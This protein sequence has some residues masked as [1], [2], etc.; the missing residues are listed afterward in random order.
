MLF[1]LN[2]GPLLKQQQMWQN[3]LK[4]QCIIQSG[5]S[6][7]LARG[8]LC[9]NHLSRVITM[10]KGTW[11]RALL[12]TKASHA[13][14]RYRTAQA[15]WQSATGIWKGNVAREDS[16]SLV[17]AKTISGTEMACFLRWAVSKL[18]LL[19]GTRDKLRISIRSVNFLKKICKG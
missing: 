6:T 11:V 1:S 17:S 15:P 19:K 7:T 8:Q 2:L 13:V 4:I 5:S 18:M 12:T 16:V 3:R 14:P 9:F 10:H